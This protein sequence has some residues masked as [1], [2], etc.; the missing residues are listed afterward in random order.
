MM[1]ACW[2]E[3]LQPQLTKSIV[4]AQSGVS[5]DKEKYQQ[6]VGRLLYLCHTRPDIAFEVTVVSRY[7]HEPRSKHLEAIYRILRYL[8]GSPQEGLIYKS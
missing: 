1:L 7:M 6:L 3:L 8:M 5:V 4:T 2:V